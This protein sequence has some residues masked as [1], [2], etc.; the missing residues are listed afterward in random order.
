MI[1]IRASQM[2]AL[3]KALA[4]D[5]RRR[6][7]AALLAI[8][9]HGAASKLTT[10][11]D[12]IDAGCAAARDFGLTSEAEVFHFLRIVFTYLPDPDPA[13][14]TRPALN[15]LMEYGVTAAARLE[16]LETLLANEGWADHA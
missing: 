3:Q 11:D 2:E 8:E 4:D 15:C 7:L 5:F 14:L 12:F 9:P 1:T 6:T 16:H 13:S 10:L